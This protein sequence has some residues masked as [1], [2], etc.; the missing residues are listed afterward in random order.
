LAESRNLAQN[1]PERARGLLH[2][3]HLWQ[4]ELGAKLPA[5]K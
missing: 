2:K 1:E 5:A 3:L 4:R